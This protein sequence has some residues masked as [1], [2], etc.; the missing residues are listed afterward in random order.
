M[1][2]KT[3]PFPTRKKTP[4]PGVSQWK[5]SNLEADALGG[6]VGAAQHGCWFLNRQL[7]FM[8]KK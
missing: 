7:R 5:R 2:E 1:N 6:L 3:L 4:F 8:K